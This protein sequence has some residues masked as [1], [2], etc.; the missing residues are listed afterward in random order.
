MVFTPFITEQLSG[1]YSQQSND[2]NQS[3]NA[4]AASCRQNSPDSA[5]QGG[6][7]AGKIRRE[8]AA[9]DF[10]ALGSCLHDQVTVIGTKQHAAEP[11]G[12]QQERRTV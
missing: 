10:L 1:Q 5:V 8:A 2:K 4:S 9:E 7:A 3:R 6:T 12:E 11:D